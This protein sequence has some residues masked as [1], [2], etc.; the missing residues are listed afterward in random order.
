MAELHQEYPHAC[1]DKDL[2]DLELDKKEDYHDLK[3]RYE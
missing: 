2:T 3:D 1:G